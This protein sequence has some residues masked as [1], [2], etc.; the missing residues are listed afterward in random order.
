MCIR[1]SYKPEQLKSLLN[2]YK[3]VSEDDLWAHLEYFLK[4][5]IPVAEEVGVRMAMH[6]DD[7]PRPIFGL[8]RIVKNR[9]DLMRL[10]SICLLY[11]SRCV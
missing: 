1:D 9:D 10:V 3:S 4:A 5:I 6:P 7:P 2:E 11:T 8:P